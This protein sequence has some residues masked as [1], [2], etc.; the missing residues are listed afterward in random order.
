MT[1]RTIMA[2]LQT[3][4]PARKGNFISALMATLGSSGTTGPRGVP[5]GPR[6]KRAR[7]GAHTDSSSW[8]HEHVS[9]Q[10]LLPGERVSNDGGEITVLWCPPQHRAGAIGSRDNLS[11]IA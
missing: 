4:A 11:G 5:D 10:F 9:L 6:G 1:S 2:M 8:V 3:F 7:N